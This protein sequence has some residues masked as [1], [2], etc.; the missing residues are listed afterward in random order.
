MLDVWSVD[1]PVLLHDCT[2]DEDLAFFYFP[3]LIG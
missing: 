3:S 1:H 2:V